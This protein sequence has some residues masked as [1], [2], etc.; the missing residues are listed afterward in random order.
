MIDL[1]DIG[2][3]DEEI[4]GH[5]ERNKEIIDGY[6]DLERKKDIMV[7]KLATWEPIQPNPF[8]VD[9]IGTLESLGEIMSTKTVRAFHYSRMTDGEVEAALSDGIV[10][11]SV[12]F[13]KKRVDRQIAAGR[14]TPEQGT[15][16][17]TR[18]P[19]HA[20]FGVRKGFW[21]TTVPFHPA[22]PAV[23]LLVEHWGGES[24]YWLF[25]GTEDEDMIDLLKGIGRGRIIEI[26]IPLKD[27]NEGLAEFSVARTAVREYAR[28][29]GYEIYSGGLD[30]DIERPLP[31]DVILRVHTEG[32]KDYVKMGSGY[33][34][35]F[36]APDEV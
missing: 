36:K 31:S 21:S 19:L 3:Y 9:Y 10:P 5:L 15:R 7:S 23:K 14:M 12:E 1:W 33:P 34:S 13:L 22:D 26:A 16:I 20:D 4:L 8:Q 24:A 28:S 11:T 18:S 27:A 25:V 32:D 2:T 17:I 29:R 6:F 30:L 35:S